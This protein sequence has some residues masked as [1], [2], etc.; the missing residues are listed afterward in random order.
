MK[1]GDGVGERVLAQFAR[2]GINL[3][4]LAAQLQVEGTKVS[5]KTSMAWWTSTPPS[6]PH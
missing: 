3:D 5:F 1:P 4:A 2:A 6:A